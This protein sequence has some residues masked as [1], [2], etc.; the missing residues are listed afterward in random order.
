MIGTNQGCQ[1]KIVEEVCKD[2]PNICVAVPKKENMV[3]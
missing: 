2:F 3:C 1:R